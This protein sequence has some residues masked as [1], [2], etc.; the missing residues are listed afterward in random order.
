ME[1]PFVITSDVFN[2]LNILLILKLLHP[3]LF[4]KFYSTNVIGIRLVR[5]PRN[6]DHFSPVM[7]PFEVRGVFDAWR[8]NAATVQNITRS[9]KLTCGFFSTLIGGV[10]R[11]CTS[12]HLFL[13]HVQLLQI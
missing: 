8:C 11:G 10:S 7:P 9:R 5:T 13:I 1:Y 4:K 3:C 6:L 12:S 2:K